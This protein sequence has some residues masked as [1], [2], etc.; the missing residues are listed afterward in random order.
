MIRMLYDTLFFRPP[1]TSSRIPG[2]EPM[3]MALHESGDRWISGVIQRGEIFDSHIL[4]VL[5]S[6]VVPGT[7]FIDVGA[8]IG[9]F[10]VIGS[11]LVGEKGNVL[12][13][14]PEPRNLR[15]LRRNVAR[16]RCRNVLILPW[17]AG[18]EARV[19]RLFRSE[20][21]QGDHRMETAS[22]RLDSVEV[23][24]KPLDSLPSKWSKNVSVIKMDT[25]GSEGAVLRGMPKLL[26]VNPRVRVVLEF[27][28]YGLHQC[29]FSTRELADLLDR[30]NGLLWLLQ[31]DG[32][33]QETS[34]E[35]LCEAAETR[36]TVATQAHADIVWLAADDQEA[37]AA[38]RQRN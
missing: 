34:P 32:T 29:G 38:M 7:T 1:E 3:T 16:N 23:L 31:S 30:R 26:A 18:A 6:F 10:S 13:I 15:L 22:D 21:N 20:D 4:A 36:F 11:R 9:W 19:A 5:R 12:A 24:V 35:G 8:N 33:A 17:A 28:P 27:W 25:Q 14:E 2:I 37:I